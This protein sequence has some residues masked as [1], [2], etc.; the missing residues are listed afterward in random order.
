NFPA[1]IA[2]YY[3]VAHLGFN[4]GLLFTAWGGG[5]VFGPLLGG[6]VHDLTGAYLVSYRVSALLC[7]AGALL[8]LWVRAPQAPDVASS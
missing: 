4:Y 7:L 8:S 6:I 5:G 3:G 2:D 1:I